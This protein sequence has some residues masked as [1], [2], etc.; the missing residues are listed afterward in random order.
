MPPRARATKRARPSSPSPDPIA[1]AAAAGTSSSSR[2]TRIKSQ[3]KHRPYDEEGGYDDEDDEGHEL[4]HEAEASASHLVSFLTGYADHH[5]SGGSS[6]GDELDRDRDGFELP[7]EDDEDD[8]PDLDLDQEDIDDREDG[9]GGPSTPSKRLKSGLIGT[10]TSSTPRKTPK[11]TPRKQRTAGAGSKTPRKTPGKKTAK[12]RLEELEKNELQGIIRFSRSDRYFVNTSKPSRTSGNS[13]SALAQPLSQAQY[14]K[15]TAHS[16][17][18]RDKIRPADFG[19]ERY[20]QWTA[21]LDGGGFGLM[22]YG[23]GSKRTTINR[24]VKER[25]APLGNV[26]VINGHFPQL[27]IRDVLSNIEDSLSIPQDIP[28]PPSSNATPLDRSAHRIYSYFQ[29][30]PP[31]SLSS[32]SPR[33]RGVKAQ[34]PKA[35]PPTSH[36]ISDKDLYLV[37]HNIDS[38]SLRSPRSLNILSLLS[39]SPRIKLIATFDHLHTPLLFS[40]ALNN[41]PPHDYLNVNNDH[42]DDGLFS[43]STTPTP[44]LKSSSTITAPTRGFNWI[45]HNLTTYAPYD[46][47]LSYLR[48]SASSHLSL[49][50]SNTDGSGIS[51]EGALQILKSVPPMAARLLKLLLVKQLANLPSDPKYHTAY[52]L[53]SSSSLSNQASPVFAVDNDILM[54]AAKEKFI[55]REEER[56]DALIGEYRD[57]GLVVEALLDGEGRTGRWVWVPLGKAAIERILETMSEVEV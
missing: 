10:S 13:Y 26:V 43:S 22:F 12:D 36:A 50:N 6:S 24:F 21:E 2:S 4:P 52:H 29:S 35:T 28:I 3:P 31:P 57:H 46:L 51:E 48:L 5:S 47:E 8:D 49:S 34:V 11:T 53:S 40:P 30:P 23:F 9:A 7:S 56:Y 27:S 55:A 14:D 19:V 45:Y 16:S 44:T 17:A 32:V 15:Y 1:L 18:I 25:L 41:T 37:I 54:A 38:P 42:V 39:S 20:D 33:K